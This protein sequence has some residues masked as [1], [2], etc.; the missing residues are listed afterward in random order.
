VGKGN[1]VVQVIQ[2]CQHDPFTLLSLISFTAGFD[3]GEET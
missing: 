1:N 2:F 3:S